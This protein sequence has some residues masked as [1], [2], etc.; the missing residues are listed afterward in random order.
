MHTATPEIPAEEPV[1]K[2][3][4]PSRAERFAG[5]LKLSEQQYQD[6]SESITQS[7]NEWK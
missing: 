2:I 7:R 5:A 4:S 1:K 6:F 3:T